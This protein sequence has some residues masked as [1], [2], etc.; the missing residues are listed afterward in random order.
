MVSQNFSQ[1]SAA[2]HVRAF[3]S[4]LKKSELIILIGLLAFSI[5]YLLLYYRMGGIKDSGIESPT[6]RDVGVYLDTGRQVLARQ[7]PYSGVFSQDGTVARS[8][9]FGP[10]VLTLLTGWIPIKLLTSIFQLLNILG[11]FSFAYLISNKVKIQQIILI[12]ILIVWSSPTREMLVT[13]QITGIVMGLIA[14]PIIIFKLKRFQVNS[15]LRN[16]LLAF[17][18]SI[19]IDLKPHI[20]LGLLVV[21]VYFEKMLRVFLIAIGELLIFHILINVYHGK[22]LEIDWFLFV[23]NLNVLGAKNQLGDSV[24][25]WPLL[26]H[27]FAYNFDNRVVSYPLIAALGILFLFLIKKGYYISALSIITFLPSLTFYFHFY[28]AIPLVTILFSV[29]VRDRINPLNL[30]VIGFLIIPS[31]ITVIKNLFLVFGILSLLIYLKRDHEKIV[32]LTILGVLTLS[33]I[34]LA[35]NMIS[36]DLRINQSFVVSTSMV[37]SCITVCAQRIEIFR[38]ELKSNSP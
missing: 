27:Y 5:I 28:D 35:R 16:L 25:Y 32:K 21:L 15:V 17:P 7:N 12:F 22:I 6:L 9:P 2:A 24:S 29:V 1:I 38:R 33:A 19:A 18:M 3:I 36:S 37:L 14:T 10:T 30:G 13:N 34:H 26:H 31:Q 4:K 20:A 11:I 8:W 23:N